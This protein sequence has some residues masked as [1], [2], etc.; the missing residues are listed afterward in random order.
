[1]YDSP[2]EAQ[3]GHEVPR[4]RAVDDQRHGGDARHV[5]EHQA[6]DAALD[7]VVLHEDKRQG[8]ADGTL[9][10]IYT[11]TA[12]TRCVVRFDH[13]GRR[14][15]ARPRL[16]NAEGRRGAFKPCISSSFVHDKMHGKQ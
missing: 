4:Q 11:R 8:K 3:V 7:A 9:R 15:A 14:T 1:M 6:P 5:E 12:L 13:A 10:V 16:D 2:V